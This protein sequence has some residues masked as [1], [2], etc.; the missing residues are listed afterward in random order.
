MRATVPWTT[1][2]APR[3]TSNSTRKMTPPTRN[4]YGPTETTFAVGPRARR[5]WAASSRVHCDAAQMYPGAHWS[6]RTHDCR[7][8]DDD[9]SHVYGTHDETTSWP[10]APVKHG[11]AKRCVALAHAAQALSAKP[12]PTQHAE[13]PG[14]TSHVSELTESTTPSPHDG[15]SHVLRQAFGRLSEFS[16]PSSH[17]S[18]PDST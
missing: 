7:H 12:H 10:H 5:N 6:S 9:A 4:A 1:A 2:T 8:T 16:A 3:K 18:T 13:P 11:P 17:V 15:R 14:P